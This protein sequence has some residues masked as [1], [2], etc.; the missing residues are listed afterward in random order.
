MAPERPDEPGE[1]AGGS[2]K[3]R[4]FLVGLATDPAKLGQF[5]KDPDS[6]MHGADLSA[7]EQT[8]L[9]SGDPGAIYA[10]LGGRPTPSPAPVTVLV[11]DL[12]SESGKE[13]PTMSIRPPLTI[14]QPF[15]YPNFGSPTLLIHQLIYPQIYPQVY[16]QIHQLIYPQIYPQVYPQIHQLIYPQIYPQVFPQIHQ[17]IQP[18]LVAQQAQAAQAPLQAPG[19][20]QITPLQIFP[21]IH[22]QIFPQIHPLIFPQIH[23]QIFPQIHPIFPQIHPQMVFQPQQ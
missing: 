4:E 7:D 2:P 9:K 22:P 20:L 23:P 18:Q 6:A 13:S 12:T 1:P 5:I 21:Q 11:V 15:L 17:L 14:Q 10:R 8:V 16:P 19:L 3:L